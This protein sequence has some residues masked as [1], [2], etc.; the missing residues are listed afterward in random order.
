MQQQTV[1]ECQGYRLFPVGDI[2]RD[3]SSSPVP[4]PPPGHSPRQRET[5]K[6][7]N[8]EEKK[9]LAAKIDQEA[10]LMKY[11]LQIAQ[12][13]FVDSGLVEDE[14]SV[15]ALASVLFSQVTEGRI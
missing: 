11:C 5:W 10:D 12:K 8:A 9:Q 1:V 4:G 2:T 7:W 3:P 15:C 6:P 14:D 13:K